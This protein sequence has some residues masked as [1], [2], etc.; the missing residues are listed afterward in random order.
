M[1]REETTAIMGVLKTA[2]PSFYRGM[3]RQEALNAI[4]LWTEMFAHD[5][6]DVVTAAVKALIK[7]RKEGYPPTVGEVSDKIRELTQGDGLTRIEAWN[8]V[9]K[10]CQNSLYGAEEEFAKLP[11]LVQKTVGSPNQLK[12]WAMMD[13]DTFSVT[14]SHF[15]RSFEI[16]QKREQ[17]LSLLPPDIRERLAGLTTKLLEG[18]TP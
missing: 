13:A 2:Y 16:M 11:P 6:A 8:L 7:T 14:G 4:S 1:T 17:E 10:A 5:R 9:A 3:T 18:T 12:E 15:Q